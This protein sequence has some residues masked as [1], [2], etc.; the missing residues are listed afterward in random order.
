MNYNLYNDILA[1]LHIKFGDDKFVFTKNSLPKLESLTIDSKE[2][3]I[4]KLWHY[5][6]DIHRVEMLDISCSKKE[7]QIL[8]LQIGRAHV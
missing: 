1:Q 7:Y 4:D 8:G 3:I 5:Y 6:D 2:I